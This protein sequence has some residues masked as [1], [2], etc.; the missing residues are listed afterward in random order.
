M[1]LQLA[2]NKNATIDVAVDTFHAEIDCEPVT[3]SIYRNDSC[4]SDS[5]TGRCWPS[6]R[7]A[8]SS[9]VVSDFSWRY[10]QGYPQ[11]DTVYGAVYSVYCGNNLSVHAPNKTLISSG[12]IRGFDQN[13][14]WVVD[15]LDN[16]TAYLCEP[17]YDVSPASVKID[18]AGNIISVTKKPNSSYDHHLGTVTPLEFDARLRDGLFEGTGMV[19]G[20]ASSQIDMIDINTNNITL[21]GDTYDLI[22][23]GFFSTL[24]IF[25]K[26]DDYAFF[27]N[28]HVVLNQSKAMYSQMAAQLAKQQFMATASDTI[29]GNGYTIKPRLRVFGLALYWM[30][31]TVSLLILLTFS[32]CFTMAPI[33]VSRDPGT[34]GG[35][36]AIISQSQHFCETLHSISI[37]TKCNLKKA[38][39]TK[40]CVAP[41]KDINCDHAFTIDIVD[42]KTENAI[43]D[44]QLLD[45]SPQLKS[46]PTQAGWWHPWPLRT[47]ISILI[48][49]FLVALIITLTVTA[50]VSERNDGLAF[51]NIDDYT[52]YAWAYIPALTMVIV[53]TL[54][55]ARYF[56]WRV[57][58]PYYELRKST[59]TDALLNNQLSRLTIQS[60]FSSVTRKQWDFMAISIAMLVSPL[61]TIVVS[62]LY[63][64]QL[65]E[66]TLAVNLTQ[67]SNF[68]PGF[69]DA[70]AISVNTTTTN[71]FSRLTLI[72]EG[73]SFMVSMLN[74]YNVTD[75]PWTYGPLAFNQVRLQAGEAELP[76]N[77]NLTVRILAVRASMNCTAILSE[78]LNTTFTDEN[79]EGWSPVVVDWNT[80]SLNTQC[81]SNNITIYIPPDPGMVIANATWLPHYEN[82]PDDCPQLMVVYGLPNNRSSSGLQALSCTV[83]VEQVQVDTTFSLPD[84]TILAAV[85]DE[86]TA[87]TFI[88]L[89]NAYA[90]D[91]WGIGPSI[92]FAG[93][94]NSSDN[95]Y[96]SGF[97]VDNAYVDYT[98]KTLFEWMPLLS[99]EDLAVTPASRITS[100]RKI[101]SALS[102]WAGKIHAQYIN[103][104]GRVPVTNSSSHQPL[105]SGKIYQP[106][107]FRL[108]QNSIPTYVLQAILLTIALSYAFS[109]CS[110]RIRRILPANPC[111]IAASASLL[112]GTKMLKRIPPR[113]EFL[114]RDSDLARLGGLDDQT[115]SLGWW[116]EYSGRGKFRIDVGRCSSFLPPERTQSQSDSALRLRPVTLSAVHSQSLAQGR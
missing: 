109:L 48:L 71:S 38:L 116:E 75:P 3:L 18:T 77:S 49:V 42:L 97:I 95:P 88:G 12:V 86:N 56:I 40:V 107:R 104:G 54:I 66:Y 84:Y 101:S 46:T 82:Q 96:A 89:G 106:G 100:S 76:Q 11:R 47:T 112:A 65:V 79:R 74:G 7:I 72:D 17:K 19:I 53:Q 16:V 59:S 70:L 99:T 98:F 33:V 37:P 102:V 4:G 9:C 83:P 85:P 13:S 44:T 80:S 111:S 43:K 6:V 10:P 92:L 14:L 61:L 32:L 113:A 57:L 25:S 39:D 64:P 115:F 110:M 5:S 50:Q 58:L 52:R 15:R 34:I 24:A 27:L 51:V 63:A 108:Q 35:L 78:N 94:L 114:K 45:Q 29:I 8:S 73:T 81:I 2:G 90:Q 1:K 26:A 103:L 68:D 62:N 69:Y 36:A 67:V 87:T 31:A 91:F 20:A 23:D 30:V 21:N 93:K 22:I 105:L 41:N 55:E 28:Q 60:L